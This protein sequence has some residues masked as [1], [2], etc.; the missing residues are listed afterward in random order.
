LENWPI[1]GVGETALRGPY[2][3]DGSPPGRRAGLRTERNGERAGASARTGVRYN[4]VMSD[5]ERV[6][7]AS[8]ESIPASDPPAGWAGEDADDLNPKEQPST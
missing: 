4:V 3:L 5:D 8:E 7:E 2:A 6:D 1:P